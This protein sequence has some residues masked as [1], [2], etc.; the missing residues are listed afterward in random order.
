MLT[1]GE[2]RVYVRN[3]RAGGVAQAVEYL[4]S[5]CKALSSNPG[6]A[7]KKKRKKFDCFEKPGYEEIQSSFMGRL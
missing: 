5:E 3:L 4:P 6:N 1:L 7:K 2:V